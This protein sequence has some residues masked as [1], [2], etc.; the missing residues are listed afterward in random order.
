MNTAPRLAIPSLALACA[1]GLSGCLGQHARYTFAP[2]ATVRV[3]STL[4]I[5]P[6]IL[7]GIL[8][9]ERREFIDETLFSA[10]EDRRIVPH[11]AN[12]WRSTGPAITLERFASFIRTLGTQAQSP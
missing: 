7:E 10:L 8:E 2:D 1:V 4:T 12:E 6:G 3:E 9:A 11:G 5:S